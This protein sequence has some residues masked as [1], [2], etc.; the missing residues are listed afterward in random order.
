M[1]SVVMN[2]FIKSS[3]RTRGLCL[4]LERMMFRNNR[5]KSHFPQWVVSSWNSLPGA[6]VG[7]EIKMP[8]NA[9]GDL[10]LTD[11]NDL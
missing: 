5:R 8:S 11:R 4:K 6:G 10:L 7:L 9:M 2:S 1:V 3:T